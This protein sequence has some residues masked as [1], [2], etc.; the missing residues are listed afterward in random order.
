MEDCKIRVM[1]LLA[2]G[3]EEVEAVTPIDYLRR[4]GIDVRVAAL[5]PDR[6]VTGS[7]D[8]SVSADTSFDELFAQE[9]LA[10]SMWDAVV[11]P[12]GSPGAVNIASDSR[13]AGFILKMAQ[14]EKWIC[15][16]CA[17][18]AVVLGPTGILKGRRFTCYPGMENKVTGAIWSEDRV[19]VDKNSGNGG[20][21]TSRGA[22]TTGEFAIAIIAN[23]LNEKDA[24]Q[25]A[26]KILLELPGQCF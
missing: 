15:A 1:V 11:V 17:S 5:G 23:I 25:I 7:H 12:G 3:F 9:K 21:I 24:G 8:I 2:P 16:I 19:V 18:P 20:I 14:A 26:G 22:G 10:P 4:A 13:I 6:I